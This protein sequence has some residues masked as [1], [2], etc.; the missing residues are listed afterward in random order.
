MGIVSSVQM[1]GITQHYLS[2]GKK[3]FVC[4]DY[5]T[6]LIEASNTN[7]LGFLVGS[8][9]SQTSAKM[10]MNSVQTGSTLTLSNPNTIPNV[11]F[12]I[13]A[14]KG[15][16]AQEYSSRQVAFSSIGDGLLDSEAT[17]L[18]NRVQNFQLAL[19]RAV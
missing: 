14:N 16:S 18:Y 6:S 3:G 12:S 13:S 4:G 8:R 7:T 11:A 5:V 1:I 19:N 15:A 9:T 17:A 2:T 10:F